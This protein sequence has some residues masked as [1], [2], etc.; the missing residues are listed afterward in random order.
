MSGGGFAGRVLRVDLDRGGVQSEPLTQAMTHEY[1]GGLGICVKLAADLMPPRVD[2]LSPESVF[3]LGAGPL[4]GTDLPSAS[5]VFVVAKLPASGTV[6]WCG[7]GGYRFG[8][9]LKY[10]GYDHVVVSGRAETPVYLLIDDDRVEIRSAESL[11]GRGVDDTCDWV[12]GNVAAGAGV[13]AIGPAGENRVAQAMAFIDRISTL[14]RGGFGAVM[15]A[16]NLKA[17]VVRGTGTVTVADRSRFR[18]LSH[19]LL[20]TIREYPYLEEWQNLGMLKAFPMVPLELYEKLKTRRAACVSCPV[21]CKDVVR[22]PD[23]RFSGL[24]KHTSSAINLF[25]PMAYGMKDPLEAVKLVA[26]LD[27]LGLDMFEF[28]G[29]MQLARELVSCGLLILEPAEP[30]IELTLPESMTAWAQRVARRQGTGNL[31][32]DGVSAVL[33]SVGPEARRRAP[34]L[35]KGMRPYAGPGAAL[36]WDRFGTMELGQVLDPRGP[37]VG[38]GGSPTYFATRPLDIFPKHLKRMGVPDDAVDRILGPDRDELHVGRLLRHSH[39]WFVTLGCL[40][41]CVRGQVNRFYD[42]DL[43][44]Q[45]YEAATGIPTS[46]ADLRRRADRVWTTLRELNVREGL[47]ASKEALPD[48]WFREPGFKNYLTGE[49]LTRQQAEEMKQEYFHEWGWK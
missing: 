43:C 30:Q 42:A 2:A 27:S 8:A 46:I 25:T 47:D 5:R 22:V 45:A 3:A 39:A 33:A 44:A 48:A 37:H 4:V 21:G 14:G 13:L 10:A 38:A 41:V 26:D 23:G 16:K 36:P 32:A 49:P 40:G 24:V 31:F 9:Q 28:F 34:A 11:W 17:I 12:H 6:G 20:Q 7:A 35:I 18:R 19:S 1:L 15:G 29:L